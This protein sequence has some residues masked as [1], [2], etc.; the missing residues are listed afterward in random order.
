MQLSLVNHVCL[1]VPVC[2]YTNGL[3]RARKDSPNT[4]WRNEGFRGFAD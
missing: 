4:G 2:R 3:R 1:Y